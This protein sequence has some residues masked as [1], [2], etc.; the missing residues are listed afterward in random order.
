MWQRMKGWIRSR[1]GDVRS[2]VY[3]GFDRWFVPYNI[4]EGTASST[5]A[6][7][8]TVFSAISKLSNSMATLPLKLYN[9][10]FEQVNNRVADLIGNA[11]NSNMTS[12]DFIRTL[13]VHRN[14]YGNAYALKMSDNRLQVDSLHILDPKRVRPVVE[15]NTRELWYEVDGDKGRYYVH[16]L[17]MIHV[18]HISSQGHVG[19]SPIEVLKGTVDFDKGVR[20]FSLDQMQGSIKASF[21]LKTKTHLSKEKKRE[22]LAHFK[23]FYQE[24][25]GV[26]IQDSGDEIEPIERNFMDTKVFEVERIT[27][28]RVASVFNIPLH[29]LGETQGESYKSMEQMA[30][31]YVQGTLLPIVRMYEQEFNRKLLSEVERRKGLGFKFN[32]GGLLRGDVKTR[33]EFYFKMIRSGGFTPN[34]VRAYEELPP[35]EGGEKLYVSRDLVPIDQLRG[36]DGRTG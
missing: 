17:D 29:M 21:I 6:S 11:P 2:S 20:Q 14:E 1:W 18:K 35:K 23:S 4:F 24:N 34:E 19:I 32:V 13:E 12:F 5:L 27:R 9:G 7:N 33:G 10:R 31:E 25:G 30:L 28:S 26:I 8:E 16:N 3:G 15:A 22:K 36:G